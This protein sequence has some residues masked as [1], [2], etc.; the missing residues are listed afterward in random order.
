M[1]SIE[2]HASMEG[3]RARRG[4]IVLMCVHAPGAG[5]RREHRLALPGRWCGL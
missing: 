2:S 3:A 1:A 4:G 5:K